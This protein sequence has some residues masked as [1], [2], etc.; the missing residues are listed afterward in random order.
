MGSFQSNIDILEVL[1]G[2]RETQTSCT[3]VQRQSIDFKNPTVWFVFHPHNCY[4]AQSSTYWNPIKSQHSFTNCSLF[5]VNLAWP[6]SSTNA[7]IRGMSIDWLLRSSRAIS[8]LW[9]I[10]VSW[11][12]WRGRQRRSLHFRKYKKLTFLYLQASGVKDQNVA[13][14]G[15]AAEP[16]VGIEAEKDTKVEGKKKSNRCGQ[17]RAKIGVLGNYLL[18]WSMW[19]VIDHCWI[20]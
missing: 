10:L 3:T 17:C 13:S 15:I 9:R 1:Q 11:L 4:A 16:N 6:I 19:I 8:F 18:L 20:L 5:F 14:E 7:S 12:G 2:C